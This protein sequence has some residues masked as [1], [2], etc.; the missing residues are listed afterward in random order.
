MKELI[1]MLW[2]GFKPWSQW[3]KE[4]KDALALALVVLV[5]I[6]AAGAVERWL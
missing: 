1:K 5:G 2:P 4:D 3:T 6:V